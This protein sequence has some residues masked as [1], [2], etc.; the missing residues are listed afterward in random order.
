MSEQANQPT[1]DIT[2]VRT[3]LFEALRG[4]GD[5]GNPMEIDRAK[6]IAEVAQTI[7]NSAKV[8]VDALRVIGGTGTG[9]I[10][11][12]PPPKQEPKPALQNLR[13][14]GILPEE[15]RPGITHPAPGHTVHKIRG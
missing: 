7:I 2:A 1:N 10:P 15:S 4:L 11:A 6:A 5:K 3:A 14:K 12:L 8:E 13:E 9:F